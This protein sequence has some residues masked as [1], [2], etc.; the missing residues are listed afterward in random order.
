MKR[1][2]KRTERRPL[3]VTARMSLVSWVREKDRAGLGIKTWASSG[4]FFSVG[5][6]RKKKRYWGWNPGPHTG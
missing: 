6:R 1:S 3:A 5:K 2:K 4:L